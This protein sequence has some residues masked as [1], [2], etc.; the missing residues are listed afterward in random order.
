MKFLGSSIH[1]RMVILRK[2][3][4]VKTKMQTICNKS[5]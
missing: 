4:P 2:K 1:C 3:Y 5:R